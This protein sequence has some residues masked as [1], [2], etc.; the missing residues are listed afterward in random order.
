MECSGVMVSADSSLDLLGSSLGL[1][2]CWDYSHHPMRKPRP[3]E[4]T[5]CTCSDS[6]PQLKS[7]LTARPITNLRSW[8]AFRWS[9][10]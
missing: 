4:E 7:Q 3:H 10:L 5:T 9:N 8:R 6:L 2:K 1:P